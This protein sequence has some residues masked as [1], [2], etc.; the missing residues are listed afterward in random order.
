MEH[1]GGTG[2]AGIPPFHVH[3]GHAFEGFELAQAPQSSVLLAR[4]SCG[5]ILDLADARFA[6]CPECSGEQP[7]CRRCAGTA[8]VI[9]HAAL[10]WRSLG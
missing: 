10:Q 3:P 9:D 4:C 7:A 6:P 5:A 8:S 2:G 1:A